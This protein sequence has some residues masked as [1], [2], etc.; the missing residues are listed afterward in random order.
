MHL[1]IAI[2]NATCHTSALTNK[3]DQERARP[4]SSFGPGLCAQLLYSPAYP[5]RL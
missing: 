4:E 1:N 5:F 2:C 3:I